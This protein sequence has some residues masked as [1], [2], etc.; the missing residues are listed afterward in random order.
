MTEEHCG[1][2]IE[3]Q[4]MTEEHCGLRIGL[5]S[6]SDQDTL[7]K[8]NI[9]AIEKQNRGGASHSP[10]PLPTR[11]PHSSMYI[12]FFTAAIAFAASGFASFSRFLA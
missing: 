7:Q 3:Q 2:R 5:N 8:R 10:L 1:L 6:N 4:L 9:T 12:T 11:T